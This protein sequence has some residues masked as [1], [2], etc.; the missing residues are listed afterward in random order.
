MTDTEDFGGGFAPPPFKPA[1]A[2]LTLRRQLR[3]LKPLVERGSRWELRGRPVVELA[4]G[5]SAIDA[6]IARRPAISPEWDR[7]RLASAPD[8]RRFVDTVRQRLA[9]WEADE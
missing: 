8:L 7:S 1:E 3:E 9:R 4:A 5:D 6:R 2:L